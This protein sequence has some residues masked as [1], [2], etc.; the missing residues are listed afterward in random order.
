MIVIA[1]LI[2]IPAHPNTIITNTAFS[3]IHAY[4]KTYIDKNETR[5]KTIGINKIH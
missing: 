2:N 5:K 1:I 3:F 4:T